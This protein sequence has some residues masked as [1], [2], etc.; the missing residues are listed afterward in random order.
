[1]A[2]AKKSVKATK[3]ESTKAKVASKPAAA[4]K[5]VATAEV[6]ET[7]TEV[8]PK[9][10]AK[11][12]KRSSKAVLAVEAE[13]EKAVRKATSQSEPKPKAAKK[14]PRTRLERASKKYRELAK[15]IDQ[16][17]AYSLK[18]AAEL[19]VKTSPAKFDA[20]V[21]LHINLSVDPKQ[22]DQNIRGA[23]V[24]PGGTGKT[25]RV[26]TVSSAVDAEKLFKQLDGNQ[27]EFDILIA[28]PEMML[29]L[30]KYARVL[31]PRGLMPSPK[32]GTVTKDVA[33]AAEEAKAGRV[34]YR[35]DSNGIVHLGIGKVSFGPEKV[36]KN[37][38]AVMS[39]ISGAKPS[40]VKGQFVKSAFITTTM[41]PSIRIGA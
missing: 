41:G 33:K 1:M 11:A 15:L 6:V 34:E 7:K 40:S 31:G 36:L 26:T 4:K 18:D 35:V 30:G 16:S 14:A 23:I 17:Q 9:P 32:S 27:I 20:A 3:P 39:A 21:E 24:L 28:T 13:K 38:E 2:E 10:L 5:V 37:A 19:A 29:Q 8:K 22:A 12:G 25:V